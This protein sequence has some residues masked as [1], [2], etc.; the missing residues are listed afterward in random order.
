MR[1]TGNERAWFRR[2]DIKNIE[3]RGK[4]QNKLQPRVRRNTMSSY[5]ATADRRITRLVFL[6]NGF[7][8]TA[9]FAVLG[10]SMDKVRAWLTS[11][12]LLSLDNRLLWNI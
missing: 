1:L 5:L 8:S 2:G 10:W 12:R 7:W 11:A 3:R 6:G 9:G 4:V